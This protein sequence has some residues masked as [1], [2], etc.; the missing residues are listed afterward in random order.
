M[1]PDL[2]RAL[3]EAG[4]YRGTLSDNIQKVVEV[5]TEFLNRPDVNAPFKD[6]DNDVVVY[7][8]E[9]DPVIDVATAQ[10]GSHEGH[11]IN[12]ETL[13]EEQ[14]KSENET[15]SESDNKPDLENDGD[16]LTF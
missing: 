16:D 6:K 3:A 9:N 13:D 5:L 10:S 15:C 11:Y 4:A 8:V 14:G 7:T 1:R 12:L 2:F